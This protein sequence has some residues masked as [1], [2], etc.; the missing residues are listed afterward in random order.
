MFSADVDDEL[1]HRGGEAP[2]DGQ[3]RLLRPV[4]PRAHRLDPPQ[5]C[6]AR[7]SSCDPSTRPT[8]RCCRTRPRSSSS[9]RSPAC[10]NRSGPRPSSGRPHR[11]THAAQDLAATVPPLLH[12]VPGPHRGRRA[13]PGP[14]VAL[15]RGEAG[16]REH[17]RAPRRLRAGVDGALGVTE[18]TDRRG[19]RPRRPPAGSG[20]DPHARGTPPRSSRP[21]AP[22]PPSAGSSRPR[23]SRRRWAS[24]AG[25]SADS[26]RGRSAHLLALDGHRVVGSLSIRRDDH[27]VDGAR[28]DPGD[29]RRRE[30]PA[31]RDRHRPVGRGAAMGT[32]AT[33]SN[34]SS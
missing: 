13:R 32:T 31:S 23:S 16:A 4:R 10:R 1:R 9:A 17:A 8:C 27:P 24:T 14:P 12:G 26:G 30:L 15:H 21:T 19:M 29:V 11:L 34:G 2:V 22:S 3:P 25:V 33:A 20:S 28:R 6:R 7:G 18:V 5:G